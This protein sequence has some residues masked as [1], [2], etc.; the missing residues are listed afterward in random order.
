ML[1]FRKLTSS[2]KAFLNALHVGDQVRFV[3]QSDAELQDIPST[4][5]GV[6]TENARDNKVLRVRELEGMEPINIYDWF[7]EIPFNIR[8]VSLAV[9]RNIVVACPV[10]SEALAV[11]DAC[12]TVLCPYC[13]EPGAQQCPK[14]NTH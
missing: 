6:V 4:V 12:N 8:Y 11:C 1:Q 5:E 14:A 9:E 10:C 7:A 2:N 3:V 13:S